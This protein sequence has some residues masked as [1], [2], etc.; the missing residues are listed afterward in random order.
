MANRKMN[1]EIKA[2]ITERAAYSN[3]SAASIHRQVKDKFENPCSLPTVN[4]TVKSF[5][6]GLAAYKLARTPSPIPNDEKL[7]DIREQLRL[8]NTADNPSVPY[9]NYAVY[10]QVI[11]M[12]QEIAELK[13]MIQI[14]GQVANLQADDSVINAVGF[15]EFG[16]FYEDEEKDLT[17]DYI[18]KE[19]KN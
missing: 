3:D 15:D 5:R 1:K 19:E 16:L 8:R 9:E 2:F 17:K 13:Q 4:K 18:E 6:Q 14:L 11:S 7:A 12:R 10:D